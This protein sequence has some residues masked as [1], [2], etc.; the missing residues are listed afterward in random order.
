MSAKLS[1]KINGK[2]LKQYCLD[3]N[4]SLS[5][6]NR[7][8]KKSNSYINTAISA[9][10]MNVI[11]YK[12][13]CTY[14]GVSSNTFLYTN[15]I[16][17][18]ISSKES[19]ETEKKPTEWKVFPVSSTRTQRSKN[20]SV[21]FSKLKTLLKNN[22]ITYQQ[23]CDDCGFTYSSIS[24]YFYEKKT[25]PL[26][27]FMYICD[28]YHIKYIDYSQ[29]GIVLVLH[30]QLY[31]IKNGYVNINGELFRKDLQKHQL[32]ERALSKSFNKDISYVSTCLNNNRLDEVMLNS[33]CKT[34]F[35][36]INTYINT[37]PLIK[38]YEDFI[39]IQR[40]RITE[41]P[42]NVNNKDDKKETSMKETANKLTDIMS[43]NQKMTL[44]INGV[45]KEYILIDAET[46][47][48]SIE[49]V[50]QCI[51]ELEDKLAIIKSL[52]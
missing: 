7:Q 28:T 11:A 27:V 4:I 47:K 19:T 40:K 17:N 44:N 24:K 39:E 22:K 31:N 49:K 20:V 37:S 15:T 5:D 8:L 3:N 41:K 45:N 52:F 29:D 50:K 48:D 38:E 30:K 1:I 2:K 46:Y 14:L 34:E 35:L 16:P 32:D 6:I 25:M 23:I 18:L 33:I 9:N 26:F 43:S 36:D 51:T 21:N 12:E 42:N 13:L 10:V